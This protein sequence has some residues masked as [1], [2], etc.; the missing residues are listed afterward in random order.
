MLQQQVLDIPLANRDVTNLI[1]LQAGVAGISN[2]AQHGRST[3]A[4]RP[5]RR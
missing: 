2:R 5:G 1:K 3:A 4:V